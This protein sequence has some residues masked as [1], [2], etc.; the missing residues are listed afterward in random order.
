MNYEEMLKKKTISAT[1][2]VKRIKD[3]E[4]VFQ[5]GEPTEILEEICV[6]KD[7]FHDLKMISMGFTNA[8]AHHI[9]HPFMNDHVKLFFS[10]CTKGEYL[11][12]KAGRKFEYRAAHMSEMEELIFRSKPDWVVTLSN[13]VVSE[14]G[15]I[16]LCTNP[17]GVIAALKSGS[18]VL[19]EI[20]PNVPDIPTDYNRIHVDDITAA[21][22]GSTPLADMPPVEADEKALKIAGY[23]AERV[24]DGATLQVGYGSVP[25]AVLSALA[26]SGKKDLGIHT[27]VFTMAMIDMLKKGIIN[28]SKKTVERGCTVFGFTA[29]NKE[30]YDYLNGNQ[31]V[32]SMPVSWINDR[33]VIAANYKLTSIN[34]CLGVDLKG[35]VSS[36]T[37]GTT[38]YSGSG[39]QLDF[40]YGARHSLGGQ[41][42]LTMNSCVEKPDGT[43]ISKITLTPPIGSVITVTR[44][45]VDKI[46]TEYG[47]ADLLYK[48]DSEKAKAL[49]AIAHPDFRDELRFQAKQVGYII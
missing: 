4:T 33:N 18:R 5:A 25:D 43:R 16:K 32:K 30:M 1:E 22:H 39:G 28:N 11:A 40:V 23:I 31:H 12:A 46:V 47:V 44:N 36:E 29:G 13:G 24:E 41:S 3:G 42:F 27:E 45:D 37:I 48:S 15:Y 14:D 21:C 17:L 2:C 6:Q 35:Q 34:A 9:M 20:N 10:Y 8:V 26:G 19:V 7:R 38:H 49:I